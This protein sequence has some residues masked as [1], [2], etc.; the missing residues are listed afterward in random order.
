LYG[1]K[2]G[3]LRKDNP[4]R[5]YS[6]ID[7]AIGMEGL[8]PM[9]GEPV[10]SGVSVGGTDPV[11]VDMVA[12][13][14]MGYDWRKLPIIREAFALKQMPITKLRPED[15]YVQSDVAEWN[16]PFYVVE[17]QKFPF[18][19]PHFGWAGHVEFESLHK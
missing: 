5:Y 18:F 7:G 8:G 2:D 13:R 11:A 4:K 3:S 10:E 1:N 19:R 16:G 9:Q 15:V 6:V 14:I 12:A 17:Q